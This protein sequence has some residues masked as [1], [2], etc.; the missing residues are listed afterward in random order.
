M[1][2]HPKGTMPRY[3]GYKCTD[4]EYALNTV[5]PE[6][7]GGFEI[8]RMLVPGMPRKHFYPRQ[9]KSPYDGPVQN[10]KLVTR[11]E[12]NTLYTECAIPWSEIPD[13]RKV[14]DTGGKIKFSYRVNDDGAGGACMELARKRSVSKK[15][16]RAFHPDWKEHWA[17]E[18]E[19]SFGK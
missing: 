2:S 7:G 17:N 11:R 1:E 9:P 15:N 5:S 19:F 12:G 14:L 10:G 18:L 16:S 8:W 13:V 3:T 6:Y 4:Y